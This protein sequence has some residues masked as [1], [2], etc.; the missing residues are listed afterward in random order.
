MNETQRQRKLA[1]W[2]GIL[3]DIDEL[4]GL[5]RDYAVD[6]DL[7]GPLAILNDPPSGPPQEITAENIE[8]MRR[9]FAENAQ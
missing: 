2:R 8:K 1:A 3:N 9:R 7:N 6:V 5:V 4:L